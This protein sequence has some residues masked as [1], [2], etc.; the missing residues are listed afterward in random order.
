MKRRGGFTLLEV[1]LVMGMIFVLAAVVAPRFSDYVPALRVTKTADRIFAWARKA[2]ADAATTGLRHRLVFDPKA[3]TFWLDY[4]ARPFKDP[5]KFAPLAGSWDEEQVPDE[6]DLETL[7]GLEDDPDNLQR[8]VLEF[9]P[10]GTAADATITVSNDRGD[11]ATI[12]VVGATSRVYI[13][14][15]VQP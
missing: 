4:E 14:V 8:R 12:K 2:R 5:G 9:R 1:I 7:D 13:E 3:K 6:V 10:D 15:P 11:R